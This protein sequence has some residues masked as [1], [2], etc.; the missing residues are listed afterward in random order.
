M[1]LCEGQLIHV[2]GRDM[3]PSSNPRDRF[4]VGG[5]HNVHRPSRWATGARQMP[6]PA[7]L[8]LADFVSKDPAATAYHLET[9]YGLKFSNL[10]PETGN[11]RMHGLDEGAKG[12][13]IGIRGVM[14]PTEQVGIIPVLTVQDLDEALESAKRAGG[15]VIMEKA[16]IPKTGWISYYIA[17]GGVTIGLFQWSRP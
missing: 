15:Q 13:S 16:E 11:Y 9:V 2:L 4:P 3:Q 10:G 12:A 1:Y 6:H 7:K 5:M 17:P 14:L 8:D